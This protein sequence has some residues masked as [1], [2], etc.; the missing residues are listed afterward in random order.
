V[1]VGARDTS[2]A[3]E[4]AAAG[5]VLLADADVRRV[6]EMALTGALVEA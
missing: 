5:N 3:A 1:L 4:N 6:T 2:Q